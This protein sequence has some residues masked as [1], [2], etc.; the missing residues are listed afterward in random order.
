[1]FCIWFIID[2]GRA[3]FSSF[4][5]VGESAYFH[6]TLSPIA[7]IILDPDPFWRNVPDTSGSTRL[8]ETCGSIH[9]YAGGTLY[10]PLRTYLLSWWDQPLRFGGKTFEKGLHMVKSSL[11]NL[12][13]YFYI[14]L[15][16]MW[17]S[18]QYSLSLEL[19]GTSPLRPPPPPSTHGTGE[20]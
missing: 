12:W 16:N 17:Y 9:P 19:L 2:W 8:L 20:Q 18:Y 6:S 1:M 7:L 3:G 15:I 13:C 4:G 5:A 10:F 11:I 14:M